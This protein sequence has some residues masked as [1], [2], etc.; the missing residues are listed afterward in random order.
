[1]IAVAI[2]IFV[3]IATDYYFNRPISFENMISSAFMAVASAG[4]A[5]GIGDV[6]RATGNI[7]AALGK[8]G[9]EIARALAH[10]ITGGFMSVINGGSFASGF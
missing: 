5:Y 6:F 8:T 4:M 10:G 7:A 1:M 3:S 2:A 9:T